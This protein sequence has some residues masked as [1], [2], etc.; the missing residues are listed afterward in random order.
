MHSAC[1]RTCIGQTPLLSSADSEEL[2]VLGSPGNEV[3][4]KPGK[5]DSQSRVDREH[6]QENTVG[7]EAGSERSPRRLARDHLETARQ[8]SREPITVLGEVCLG[9]RPDK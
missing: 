4:R 9:T 1:S 3:F 7:D 6:P 8:W 2:G 5:K